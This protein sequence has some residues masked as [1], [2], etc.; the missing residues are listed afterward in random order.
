MSKFSFTQFQLKLLMVFLMLLDH[1]HQFI[2]G[3]PLFFTWLGR[4]VAPT[5][6]FLVAE[7]LY[8][9]RDRKR[10]FL[11]LFSAGVFM[12]LMNQLIPLLVSGPQI[13]NNIF[14]NLAAAVAFWSLYDE[15]EK[16]GK[17]P[18]ASPALALIFLLSLF[19]EGAFLGVM[20]VGI[21]YRL[22]GERYKISLLYALL[23]FSFFPF[24]EVLSGDLLH[25]F[26]ASFQWMMVLALPFILRY[27]GER[28][29]G[30]KGVFY[31]F[32]PLHIYALYLIGQSIV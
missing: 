30:W 3:T 21:F 13:P 32:Y 23:S 25:A 19:T 12:A 20:L 2:P 1:I 10:Y 14:L 11:R 22:R 28:G 8:H 6:M 15:A 5:F 24:S 17:L 26:S 18:K 4:L 29:P 31:V 9:T 7:G 27:N 16:R